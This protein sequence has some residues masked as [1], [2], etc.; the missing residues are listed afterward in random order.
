MSTAVDDEEHDRPI[1][2]VKTGLWCAKCLLP[3]GCRWPLAVQD[4]VTGRVI[5]TSYCITCYECGSVL[6]PDGNVIG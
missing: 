5:G 2:A 4:A 6:D 3:S 1:G